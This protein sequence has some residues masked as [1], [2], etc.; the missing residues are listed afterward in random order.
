MSN[1][2]RRRLRILAA[3]ALLCALVYC[4]QTTQMG[5]SKYTSV[6]AG[7]TNYAD[8]PSSGLSTPRLV[9]NSSLAACLLLYLLW[10]L[11][12]DGRFDQARFPSLWGWSLPFLLVALA[13]YPFTNDVYIYLHYGLMGWN[14]D[15]PYLTPA[16]KFAS[17]V[18]PFLH[19]DQTS[20][21]GP[22]SEGLYLIAS[23][24]APVSPA[25]AVY[26]FKA[27]AALF[28]TLN[29]Y[30]VW[31]FLAAHPH[32]GTL[33]LAYLLNPVLLSEHVASAHI[34]VVLSTAVLLAL[35]WILTRRW[36]LAITA[37]WAG[38]LIKTVSVIWLPLLFVYLLRQRLWRALA[39]AAFISVVLVAIL[40]LTILPSIDAWRSLVNPGVSGMAARAY[41]HVFQLTLNFVPGLEYETKA[42]ALS[43]FTSISRALFALFYA[44][45][46]LRILFQRSFT[47][48]NLAAAL[49]W[50][51]LVLFLFA[52]PWLMPWYPTLL[53]PIA[54]LCLHDRRFVVAAFVFT[55]SAALIVGAGGGQTA[56]SLIT[57]LT[58][59]VPATVVL[60]LPRRM[61]DGLVERVPMLRDP[62]SHLIAGFKHDA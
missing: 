39:G 6:L 61:I 26:L 44:V 19:W 54:V 23:S 35:G 16:H 10:L 53:L 57:S 24:L 45:T 52:T 17:E 60:L 37:T 8:F 34:D 43:V 22:I 11:W 29:G 27:M 41:H 12:D 42:D 62:S 7:G 55:Y 47:E 5:L 50:T 49:G 13:A 32:R 40:S 33:A 46:A 4:I 30:L 20:T 56:L 3:L 51:T 14:G 36:L 15:N 21:Y 38:F 9:L 58:T 31:R 48:A 25:L 28:H 18:T 1:N 59:V 2:P